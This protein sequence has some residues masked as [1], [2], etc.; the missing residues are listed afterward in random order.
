MLERVPTVLK[1]ILGNI[2]KLIIH[3]I[4]NDIIFTIV[5]RNAFQIIRL[6]KV[7][8]VFIG[9]NDNNKF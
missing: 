6:E 1:C 3:I 2:T 5:I 8:F 7:F 9:L 4:D